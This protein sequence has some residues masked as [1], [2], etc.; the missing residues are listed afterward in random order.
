[1]EPQYKVQ[2]T[3]AGKA[4]AFY[5]NSVGTRELQHAFK[6]L[7][8]VTPGGGYDGFVIGGPVG[9]AP[10]DAPQ[11]PLSNILESSGLSENVPDNMYGEPKKKSKG[12]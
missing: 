11:E 4:F 5:T 2:W 7:V 1:M 8:R 9:D 3:L 12:A 10:A 6:A